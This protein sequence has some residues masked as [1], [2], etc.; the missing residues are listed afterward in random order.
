LEIRRAPDGS[1]LNVTWGLALYPLCLLLLYCRPEIIPDSPGRKYK[2]QHDRRL[3]RA[4]IAATLAT[5]IAGPHPN[6]SG[7]PQAKRRRGILASR[8]PPTGI[9]SLP[10]GESR[11]M[12]LW[13]MLKTTRE[14]NRPRHTVLR[15][16]DTGAVRNRERLVIIAVKPSSKLFDAEEDSLFRGGALGGRPSGTVISWHSLKTGATA[17]REGSLGTPSQKQEHRAVTSSFEDFH[18]TMSTA[19][20]PSKTRTNSL[21]PKRS[22]HRRGC[23][24]NA[25]YSSMRPGTKYGATQKFGR[26]REDSLTGAALLAASLLVT[27]AALRSWYSRPDRDL[28]RSEVARDSDI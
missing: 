25:R 4:S 26:R 7:P 14:H 20:P 17:D 24:S 2:T 5:I 11:H 21:K 8:N 19:F 23:K 16:A 13:T 28:A 18:A 12:T 15:A 10:R 3:A 27:S 9:A 1:L 6:D 22:S